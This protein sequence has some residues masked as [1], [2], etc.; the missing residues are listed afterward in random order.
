MA[1]GWDIASRVLAR[2]G[3]GLVVDSK[4]VVRLLA[5]DKT[6]AVAAVAASNNLGGQARDSANL[7]GDVGNVV[8][9]QLEASVLDA[10]VLAKVELADVDVL[11]LGWVRGRA[12]AVGWVGAACRLGSGSCKSSSKE[13]SSGDGE[14]HLEMCVGRFPKESWE[15]F[16]VQRLIGL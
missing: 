4:A 16:E 10:I 3:A 9:R 13:S 2:K 1:V 7:T 11:V 14:L 15:V 6:K 8:A 12:A 5:F